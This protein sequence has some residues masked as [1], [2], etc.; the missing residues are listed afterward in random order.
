M[1]AL[2]A[3]RLADGDVVF[4]NAGQ[5]V[6][7]FADA[8][9]WADDDPAAI[10]TLIGYSNAKQLLEIARHVLNGEL[11]T[12]TRKYD[13]A[14]AELDRAVRLDALAQEPMEPAIRE[15]IEYQLLYTDVVLRADDVTNDRLAPLSEPAQP[16]QKVDGDATKAVLSTRRG[17]AT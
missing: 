14:V 15:L 10:E 4:W 7:R 1:K 2:T 5:W 17:A 8:Q 3:N 16:D 11:L 9:L 6:E 12:K 13:E